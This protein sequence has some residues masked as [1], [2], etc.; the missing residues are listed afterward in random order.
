MPR[1]KQIG[2]K[3]RAAVAAAFEANTEVRSLVTRDVGIAEGDIGTVDEVRDGS[4]YRVRVGES[5]DSY[6]WLAEDEIEAVSTP[7]TDDP[8]A[9]ASDET[10]DDES[11]ASEDETDEEETTAS[12]RAKPSAFRSALAAARAAERKRITGILALASKASL[13]ALLPLVQDASC[14]PEAAAHRLLTGKVKGARTT[15]LG[16]LAGDE[17][18]L[19]AAR[20]SGVA[21]G[22]T[23]QSDADRIVATAAL[24]NPR[25]IARK[26]RG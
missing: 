12:R 8:P 3:R 13:E 1:L 4:F 9:D 21:D 22:T 7:V 14:T 6:A 15:A 11:T 16:Q 10:D 24:F 26:P 18:A 19:Q 2:A 5:D 20:V 17:A 23:T 25:A